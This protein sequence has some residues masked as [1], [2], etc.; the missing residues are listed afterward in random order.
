MKKEYS[1]SIDGCDD[2]T[3]VKMELDDAGFTVI[4]ELSQKSHKNST[5]GCMPVITIEGHEIEDE[6]E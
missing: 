6:D 5:Y 3:E 1:I 2:S 4:Y